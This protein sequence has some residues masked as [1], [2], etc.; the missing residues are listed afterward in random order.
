MTRR[1]ID[2]SDLPA[3]VQRQVRR[4]LPNPAPEPLDL[5]LGIKLGLNSVLHE[6]RAGKTPRP[7]TEDR[8]HAIQCGIVAWADQPDSLALHPELK[9]MFAVPNESKGAKDGW[10]KKQRGRKKGQCDLCL[11]IARRD[12][13]TR[14]VYSALHIEVKDEEGGKLSDAQRDR[15]AELR[16]AGNR[17]EVVMSVFAGVAVL[18]LYLSYPAP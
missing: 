3:G 1:P 4:R 9:A 10:K 18:R 16:G 2:L 6:L 12:P 11:P 13:V 5:R 8:E 15:I 17:C 7:P 14:E